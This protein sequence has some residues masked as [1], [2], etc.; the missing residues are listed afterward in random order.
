MIYVDA[1]DIKAE[2]WL[3]QDSAPEHTAHASV[4]C[5]RHS[6]PDTSH[7]ILVTVWPGSSCDVYARPFSWGHLAAEVYVNKPCIVRELKGHIGVE[8]GA[9]CE[10]LG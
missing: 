4:D 9:F 2:L 8:I 5:F 10:Q 7:H 3:Q 6:F 1:D